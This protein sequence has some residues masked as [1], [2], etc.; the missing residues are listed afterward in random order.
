[1][2]IDCVAAKPL[3]ELP[4]YYLRTSMWVVGAGLFSPIDQCVAPLKNVGY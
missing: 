1:M 4:I 2:A 3:E